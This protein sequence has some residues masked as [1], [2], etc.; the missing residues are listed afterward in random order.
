MELWI[1]TYQL[2]KDGSGRQRGA[3]VQGRLS[4]EVVYNTRTALLK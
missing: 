3:E 1:G 2:D 4:A